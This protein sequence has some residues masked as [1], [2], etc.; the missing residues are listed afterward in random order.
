VISG[1]IEEEFPTNT[2][3][4]SIN[5]YFKSLLKDEG[6]LKLP[7][8]FTMETF[9]IVHFSLVEGKLCLWKDITL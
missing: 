2:Q 8:L 1:N 5:P 7:S 6:A 3:Q 4:L 9:K